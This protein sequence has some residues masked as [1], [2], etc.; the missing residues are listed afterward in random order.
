MKKSKAAVAKALNDAGIPLPKE[1]TY[2][3]MMHRLNTWSA[4]HGYLFRRMKTRYFAQQQLPVDIPMGTVVWMPNC[5]FART[6][7]KTKAMWFLGR[8][9]FD[10][11]Y[12][13]IDVPQTEEYTEPKV[14]KPKVEKKKSAPKIKSDKK[15]KKNGRDSNT[16]A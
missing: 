8:A 10:E 7:F 16:S 14:E 3:S 13:L 5:D 11:K 2:D 9:A 6:V 4:G 1:D 15:V 12:T